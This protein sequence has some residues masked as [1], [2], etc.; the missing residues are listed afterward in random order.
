MCSAWQKKAKLT[1]QKS[2]DVGADD[3][4]TDDEDEIG[5]IFE[6]E[7]KETKGCLRDFGSYVKFSK[8]CYHK[9]YKNGSVNTY[10][11]AQLFS[12]PT[13]KRRRKM[14]SQYLRQDSSKESFIHQC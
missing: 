2:G 14:M 11:S 7:G 3:G 4:S 6:L 13:G 12:A 5:L 9:G 8:E 10:L 1:E